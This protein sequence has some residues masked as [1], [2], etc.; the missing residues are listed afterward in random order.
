MWR[1]LSNIA[2]TLRSPVAVR[3]KAARDHVAQRLLLA[4]IELMDVLVGDSL[5]PVRTIAPKC[6]VTRRVAHHGRVRWW[7][8]RCGGAAGLSLHTHDPL[9]AAQAAR[10]ALGALV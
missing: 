10:A 7:V 1:R 4:Q 2:R 8:D 5:V 3:A 6:L 9:R